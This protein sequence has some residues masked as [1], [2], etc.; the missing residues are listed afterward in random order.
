LRAIIVAHF[1]VLDGD[2]LKFNAAQVHQGKR[3]RPRLRLRLAHQT[4][5]PGTGS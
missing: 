3:L 5:Q 1:T 4:R 2:S